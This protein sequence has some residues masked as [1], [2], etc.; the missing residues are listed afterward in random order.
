M[1]NSV[2]QW[3]PSKDN[4]Q[5]TP[6]KVA[7]LEAKHERLKQQ[8]EWST[9]EAIS[10]KE[11]AETI[12][13]QN[14]QIYADLVEKDNSILETIYSKDPKLAEEVAKQFWVTYKDAI[15]KVKG[16]PA[17][18]SKPTLNKDELFEEFT[19]KQQAKESDKVVQSYLEKLPEETQAQVKEEYEDLTKGKTMTPEKAKKTLDMITSYYSKDKKS[20]LDQAIAKNVW[21]PLSYSWW[22]KKEWVSTEAK[23]YAKLMWINL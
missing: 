11:R 18:L 23:A 14:I 13:Q 4:S 17:E 10:Q 9:K 21:W 6:D 1:D 8:Y 3:D 20:N 12:F 19:A 5:Q 7:D 2:I 15:A 22:K 16:T